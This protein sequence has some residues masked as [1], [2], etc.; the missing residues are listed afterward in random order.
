MT[1][2]IFLS[3]ALFILIHGNLPAAEE[4]KAEVKILKEGVQLT[5]VAEHPNIVTPTGIDIDDQGNIWVVSSHTHMPGKTYKGPKKDEILVFHKN[6]KRS[7]FYNKTEQTMDLELDPNGWVYLAE[8]DRILRIKDSNGDGRGDVEELLAELSSEAIY[9]HNALS[10][11]A[12]TPDGDLC[13]GLGE[14]FSK[15]WTLTGRD[16]MKFTGTGEGGIFR[17]RP[18]G[19]KLHR[20]ARGMWNPFGLLVRED[21]EIFATDNDPGVRPPCRL[22]HIVQG[23]DYGYQRLYGNEA[24]HPFVCWNGE[25]RGTLP[26]VHPVGEAPC[27]VAQLGRGLLLPSWSDHL[28]DFHRLSPKGASYSSERIALIRGSRYFRPVCIARDKSRTK[29]EPMTW[30]LS[31]WVDGRYPVHGYGRLW[32]LEIDLK[33]AKWVGP[34][35][36][37]K[38]NDHANLAKKLRIGKGGFNRK[39]LFQYSQDK[40]PFIARGALIALSKQA[41]D[42]KKDEI[43][44]LPAIERVQAVIALRIA[45]VAPDPWVKL[46]LKDKNQEVKFET[47]RWISDAKLEEYLP[48]VESYLAN[49]DLSYSLFEAAMAT[50]NTLSGKPEAGIRNPNMLIARVKDSA[51]SPRIRAYALRLL[52]SQPRTA[53]KD[54]NLPSMKFPAGLTLDL[55]KELLGLNDET[56]SLE[57]IRTLAS[58]PKAGQELLAEISTEQKRSAQLRA[59]AIA[60]LASVATK[61]HPL[62][63]KLAGDVNP[64]IREEALRCL[65][66]CTLTPKQVIEIKETGTKH[67]GSRELVRAILEP[68]SLA[69]NRPAL[70]DTEG[71][72]KR[73]DAIKAPPNITRGRR[74]FH[75]ATVA[76]CSKCHRHSGR[77]NVVG[78]NLSTLADG[79]DR[80]WLLQSILNPNFEIAPEYS[81]RLIT[82]KDG[83]T[84][85]GIRLRSSTREAMR[86]TNGQTRSFNRDD[87]NS[88]QELQVSFMPSGLPLSLT[89]RELRDLIS[90]L[91]SPAA[92]HE[93]K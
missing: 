83:T 86:D 90:F 38:K 27:G 24:H 33:K 73:I 56:L 11:L 82:L 58:N 4:R 70:T 88:I 66:S 49:S 42:W 72:L 32:K 30:Y 51:S 80:K 20:I 87:I 31:D 71:W 6:G 1:K 28:L 39:Q 25:L 89:D 74:I 85:T 55:L 35:E 29:N 7:V 65:R 69:E 40:D 41:S 59:E 12:W 22:L 75:H 93:S 37:Q 21:G 67:P 45:G 36:L 91:E 50:Q 19:T 76:L 62:L 26:M 48:N 64:T 79:G 3:T 23:G 8:R 13:F 47:L 14:N 63:V 57:V 46:F 54:G 5:L 92:K 84:F 60:G 9:P 68:G 16:G 61:H 10:A 43:Q 34:L 2:P 53:P 81:P 18:D 44:K 78:P 17:C 15:T 77:G 52:P